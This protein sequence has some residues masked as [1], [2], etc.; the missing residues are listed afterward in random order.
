MLRMR[1]VLHKLLYKNVEKDCY[2]N[3]H[4]RDCYLWGHEFTVIKNTVGRKVWKSYVKHCPC[5]GSKL[6]DD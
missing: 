4:K 3:Y 6:K 2:H 1:K 5:C